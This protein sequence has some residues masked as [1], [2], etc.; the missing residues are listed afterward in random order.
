MIVLRTIAVQIDSQRVMDRVGAAER[1]ALRVVGFETMRGAQQLIRTD[2]GTSRPGRPPFDHT[3]FYRNFIRY[4]LAPGPTLLAGPELV[5]RKSRDVVRALEHG[6]VSLTAAGER[7]VIRAR[8]V[9]A[10]TFSVVARRV[11]PRVLS[12]SITE[13]GS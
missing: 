3:G 5:T 2:R 8:P 9:M 7:I 10:P 4:A 12:D 11:L 6:G 13:Q 1:R